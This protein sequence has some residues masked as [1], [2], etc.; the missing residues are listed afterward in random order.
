MTFEEILNQAVAMLQRHGRMTYRALRAQFQLDDDLLDV[1]KDELLFAHPVV[2][3]AGRGL[4]WTGEV[5]ALSEPAP[6][7]PRR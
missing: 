1:L 4:V 6:I 3:E 5:G 7:S 2:D